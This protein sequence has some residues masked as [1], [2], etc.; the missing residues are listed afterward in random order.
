MPGRHDKHKAEW[1]TARVR[2]CCR[3]R[4][5]LPWEHF[6]KLRHGLFGLNTECKACR[7]HSSK[8][9][10]KTVPTTKRMLQRAKSRAT[11]RGWAYTI[12]EQDV[13]IPKICPI[14]GAPLQAGGPYA[15]SID[16]IDPHKGYTPDNVQVISNRANIL[17]SNGTIEEFMLL[18]KWFSRSGV[19]EI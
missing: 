19:C 9:H 2:P 4:L 12:T 15:P 11:K 1:E 3:C 8:A 14:L 5:L 7:K 16:R 13:P 17:K 18:V 6:G 10:W